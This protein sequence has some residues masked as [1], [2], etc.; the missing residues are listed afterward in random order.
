MAKFACD[1]H[2]KPS[3]CS[4][5][6]GHRN[7]GHHSKFKPVCQ[8]ISNRILVQFGGSTLKEQLTRTL[9]GLSV[10]TDPLEKIVTMALDIV[11]WSFL[12]HQK[13]FK[14]FLQTASLSFVHMNTKRKQSV[15]LVH[16][17][18][19]NALRDML[20]MLNCTKLTFTPTQI[21]K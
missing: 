3:A 13:S 2:R 10:F 12:S 17:F 21:Q 16:G 19:I 11:R 8:F 20:I 7:V 6:S 15:S 18:F 5:R 14:M 4:E 1:G 9:K